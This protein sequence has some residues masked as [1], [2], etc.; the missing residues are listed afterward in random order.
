MASS[1][2]VAVW[3]CFAHGVLKRFSLSWVRRNFVK[4]SFGLI[5]KDRA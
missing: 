4:I 3:I 1:A 2:L 5:L